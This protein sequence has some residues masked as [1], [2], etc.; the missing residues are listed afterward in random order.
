MK[1]KFNYLVLILGFFIAFQLNFSAFAEEEM[2][3]HVDKANHFSIPYPKDWVKDVKSKDY[4]VQFANKEGTVSLGVMVEPLPE[5]ASAKTFLQIMEDSMK[6]T[7]QLDEK[8]RMVTDSDLNAYG[9]DDGYAGRYTIDSDKVKVNQ[10]IIVLMK[11][12]NA[13]V[14]VQTIWDGQPDYEKF[15]G[16]LNNMSNY[17][18]IK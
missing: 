9:A 12:K 2:G 11:G 18:K 13:Y 4:K 6:V 17:F 16:I 1:K 15:A 8:E 7:N 14:V 5:K 10:S 3:H